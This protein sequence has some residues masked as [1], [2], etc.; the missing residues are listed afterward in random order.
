MLDRFAKTTLFINLLSLLLL[1]IL[2]L[3]LLFDEL[4]IISTFLIWALGIA[5][6]ILADWREFLGSELPGRWIVFRIPELLAVF[7]APPLMSYHIGWVGLLIFRQLSVI[8]RLGWRW[9][10]T[11]RFANYLVVR[12]AQLMAL[13]FA[14]LIGF[15]TLL[16]SFPGASAREEGISFLDALFTS[17]S[18][19]CVTGLIVLD[20]P[21]DFSL[22]GQLVI[23][24]LIQIG[25][26]GIMTLSSFILMTIGRRLGGRSKYVMGELLD[27]PTP[28]Q[29]LKLL[30]IIVLAT[31]SIEITG[32][33]I[34]F[35]RWFDEFSS[36]FYA[37]YSAIFH[38]ISAFCN[39]GFAL[40]SDSLVRFRSDPIVN[41][42]IMGLILAGS[43]GFPVFLSIIDALRTPLPA[44]RET[45][46]KKKSF[47][48]KLKRFFV[49]LPLNTKIV[50]VAQPLLVIAAFA[51]I[52]LIE[53]NYSLR[54]LPLSEQLLSSLFQSVTLRTAGFNTIDLT[55]LSKA[56]LLLM[57]IWMFIG[58]CSA[59]TAGGVKVNTIAL[60]FLSIRSI[61]I[62]REEVEAFGRTI[63]RPVV[64]KANAIFF[65]FAV[66]LLLSTF[67]LLLIQPEL[68]FLHALFE[69]TSALGTVGLSLNTTSLLNSA[70]KAVIIV[71]M[72]IG[73]I[74]PLTLVLALGERHKRGDYRFPT[75]RIQVG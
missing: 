43:L 30:K 46:Y 48:T 67:T 13:S 23:L 19:S 42:T 2:G 74:G 62:H 60:I 28:T 61:L 8:G 49:R 37:M 71:L 66:I 54:D 69:T 15:G 29:L 72:F 63:P 47:R 16:L 56:T 11:Q 33:L 25:G 58:G 18:A 50:L 52:F 32:A 6:G 14:L 39:A 3:E 36:P 12:P 9:E 10:A 21:N 7:I 34:L 55:H 5:L 24:L 44:K 4:F 26:L 68:P 17:T 41:F 59:G 1:L 45:H 40:F 51:I 22:F 27:E 57:I 35:I 53:R 70:G 38:S 75:E 64:R 65:T 73:R 20:T 31:L